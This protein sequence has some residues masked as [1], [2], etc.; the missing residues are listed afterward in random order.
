MT[1]DYWNKQEEIE[2]SYIR[3]ELSIQQKRLKKMNLRCPL[4]GRKLQMVMDTPL[5][6]ICDVKVIYELNVWV[7]KDIENIKKVEK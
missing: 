6:P 2:D 3:Y 5:C 7:R 4:C 1:Y